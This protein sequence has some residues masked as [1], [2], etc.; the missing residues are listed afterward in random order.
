VRVLGALFRRLV[1]TWLIALHESSKLVF[2]GGI[3]HLIDRWA[4]LRHLQPV[5]KRRW[6]V[7]LRLEQRK[8]KFSRPTTRKPDG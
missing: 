6:V 4:L 8:K 3:A 7:Y 2:F 5:R 1:L